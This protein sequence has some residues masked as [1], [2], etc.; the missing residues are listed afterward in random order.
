M[1]IDEQRLYAR[2]NVIAEAWFGAIELP[3]DND[4][5]VLEIAAQLA[6]GLSH[7]ET[8]AIALASEEGVDVPTPEAS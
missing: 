3:V 6:A 2:M 5:R 1:T 7:F 8:L 4:E